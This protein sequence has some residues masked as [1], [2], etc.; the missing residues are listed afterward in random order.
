MG[1]FDFDFGTATE[2]PATA[3]TI[4]YSIDIEKSVEETPCRKCR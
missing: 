4:P 1:D 3:G 2:E